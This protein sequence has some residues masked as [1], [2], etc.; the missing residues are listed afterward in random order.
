MKVA[1]TGNRLDTIFL[2][3]YFKQHGVKSV[4]INR[5]N[6]WDVLT[7][8][9]SVRVIHVISIKP[10]GHEGV[11]WIFLFL[12][13]KLLN[14]RTILHWQGS[15]VMELTPRYAAFFSK[16]VDVHLSYATWLSDELSVL[17]IESTWL[18]IPPPLPKSSF[19]LPEHFTVLTYLG[20]GKKKNAFYGS[21]IVEKLIRALPRINFIIVGELGNS[22]IFSLPNA[23]YLGK[24]PYEKM[25]DIYLDS[26]VLLRITKHDGLAFMVLE[27]LMRGRYVIWSKPFPHCLHAE[28]YFEALE[29]VKMY[30]E[31]KT[32]N[33][34]GIAFIKD[35]FNSIK[36]VNDL[37]KIYGDE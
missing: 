10:S 5:N 14:K 27:A 30:L 15:D 23:R 36:I 2:A 3:D 6:L 12:A 33:V 9:M 4:I 24:V 28:N 37:L 19:P 18:P 16:V 35:N 26:T 7:K 31:S 25:E 32:L 22:D 20:G 34:K 29:G 21:E 8:I 11:I 1:L 17:G 13:L